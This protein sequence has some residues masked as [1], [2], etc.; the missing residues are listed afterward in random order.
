MCVCVYTY[1]YVFDFQKV[2]EIYVSMLS[3]LLAMH[4]G[5]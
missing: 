3:F 2:C 1:I 5:I 4:H